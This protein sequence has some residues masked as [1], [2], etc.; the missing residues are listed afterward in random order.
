[1]T[2][3]DWLRAVQQLSQLQSRG[4]GHVAQSL[5]CALAQTV[6]LMMQAPTAV[7]DAYHDLAESELDRVAT[8]QQDRLDVG[9]WRWN[10]EQAGAADLALSVGGRAR[11]LDRLLAHETVHDGPVDNPNEAYYCKDTDTFVVPRL[12]RPWVEGEG[13]RRFFRRRGTPLHRVIPR[14]TGSFVQELYCLSEFAFDPGADRPLGAAMFERFKLLYEGDGKTL[15][16]LGVE[17]PDAEQTIEQQ[18]WAAINARCAAVVWP[19]L[20]MPVAHVS[21]LSRRLEAEAFL[22]TPALGPS[23]VLAGSWNDGDAQA[24]V[25]PVLDGYGRHVLDCAKSIAYREAGLGREDIVPEFHVPILVT[26]TNLIAFGICR[27]FCELGQQTPWSVINVDLV[28]VA[29]MGSN[30]RTMQSH[31]TAA[32]MGSAGGQRSFIVQQFEATTTGVTGWV[33]PPTGNPGAL[34]I[35]DLKQGSWSEHPLD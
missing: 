28:V 7:T 8:E 5:R 26:E 25:A 1:M 24:N 17:C 31:R 11:G 23:W 22:A 13:S 10:V 15:R 16:I 18:V 6:L 30:K 4:Q 2:D 12:P 19:E 27:D 20:T 33:L 29:S 14:K 34:E 35:D 32:D 21:A 9:D 3:E